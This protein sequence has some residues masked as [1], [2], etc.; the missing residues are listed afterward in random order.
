MGVH[1]NEEDGQV[2]ATG[3][4]QVAPGPISASAKISMGP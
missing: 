4:A 2:G 1:E 3:E